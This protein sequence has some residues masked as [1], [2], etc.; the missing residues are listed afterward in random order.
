M[1]TKNIFLL[2]GAIII[3]LVLVYSFSGNKKLGEIRLDQT[4]TVT[5]T[6]IT[7]LSSSTVTLLLAEDSSV[8]FRAFTN[9]LPVT[10]WLLFNST[11]TGFT[12]GRGIP[13]Y[14]SSTLIL[15][16][17]SLWTGN[18]YSI[19]SAGSSSVAIMQR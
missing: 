15:S 5:S 1:K 12:A 13:L 16:G 6:A 2:L 9:K 14:G 18:V 8:E 19:T 7:A 10:V 17:D 3:V 4:R 11:S